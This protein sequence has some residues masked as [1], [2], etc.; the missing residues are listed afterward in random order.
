MMEQTTYHQVL[1]ISVC[2]LAFVLL[3]DSGLL[4]PHSNE[5]SKN[6]QQYL[7]NVIGVTASVETTELNVITAELT[8]RRTQLDAREAVIAEREIQLQSNPVL[9]P[10]SNTSTFILSAVLF[11][12]LVLIVL[13]YGLDY[14]RL[15]SGRS[16]YA[17]TA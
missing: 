12:L 11:I 9:S 17:K 1:R 13:N 14:A 8:E 4:I 6:T 16:Q 5:V 3:F 10:T 7:A 2:V 15:R